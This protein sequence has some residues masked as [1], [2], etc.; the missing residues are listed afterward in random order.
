MY[1]RPVKLK[2]SDEEGTFLQFGLDTNQGLGSYSVALIEKNDGTV[3][4][5]EHNKFQFTDKQPAT[6]PTEE[7]LKRFPCFKVPDGMELIEWG[8]NECPDG[9]Y[10]V[11]FDDDSNFK[12][13]V[14]YTMSMLVPW[15][16]Y[17]LIRPKQ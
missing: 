4:M 17:F 7:L 3:V 9:C 15:A 13:P 16:H 2:T 6:S 12:A 14:V 10:L 11:V 8:K 1:G 5:V